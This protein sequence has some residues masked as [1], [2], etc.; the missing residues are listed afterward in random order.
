MSRSIF[1]KLEFWQQLIITFTIG[2]IILAITT[3]TALTVIANKSVKRQIIDQGL[4]LTDSIGRQARLALLYQSAVAA[5]DTARIALQFPDVVGVE[6][7]TEKGETLFREGEPVHGVSE[8]RVPDS[9]MLLHEDDNSLLFTAPV[10][11][12]RE[13]ELLWN[14]ESEENRS[15][16]EVIGYV[17]LVLSKSTLNGM[18]LQILRS[19]IAISTLVAIILLILLLFLT[20]RLTIPIRELSRVMRKAQSGEMNL[21]SSL[22][23]PRDIENM[24]KAFNTMMASLE[25]RTIELQNARDQALESAKVKSEFAANVSHELRTPMN[26]VVGMLDLLSVM[27]L[28]T[29]QYEYVET[30]KMSAQNLLA[31]IDDILSYVRS[32]SGNV[33]IDSRPCN[34]HQVLE[35]VINL[36][37]TQAL[38]KKL[39]VGY[40]ISPEVSSVYTDP[41]RLRQV[42]INLMGNA[43]KFTESGEISVHVSLEGSAEKHIL[44]VVNDTGIGISQEAQG[45]VFEA[46][47]QEDST[48]TRKYGGTG[49]GL[50]IC[51]QFIELMG[52]E[53]ALSS[54]QGAG[55]QFRFSVPYKP[56][57]PVERSFNRPD[58]SGMKVLAA[59]KSNIVRAFLSAWFENSGAS[60]DMADSAMQLLNAINEADSKNTQ[61][62]YIFIDENIPGITLGDLIPLIRKHVSAA[63]ADIV[64]LVNPWAVSQTTKLHDSLILEKPLFDTKL[65][66]FFSPSGDKKT[67]EGPAVADQSHDF[68]A[69]F[70][71]KVLVV[72]DNQ[73][74][75]LVAGGMLEKIGCE[76]ECAY[77]G[78][79]A[80]DLVSRKSFDAVLMDC[81]MPVMDG[82][83]A[84]S[85]IRKLEN[86][87]RQLPIIAMTANNSPEE[88]EHCL[89][90]G[91][92]DVI[93]KPLTIDVLQRRLLQWVEGKELDIGSGDTIEAENDVET[94]FDSTVVGSLKSSVGEVFSAVVEAFLEDVPM[95]LESLKAA[96]GQGDSRQ[97]YELAHTIKGSASNFGAYKVSTIA[98]AIEEKGQKEDLLGTDKLYL[99][100]LDKCKL[101]SRDL[102]NYLIEYREGKDRTAAKRE[103]ISTILVADDDRS[104]RIAFSNALRDEG[105]RILEASNGQSALALCSRAMP[106]L[107]LIDA[108][109]PELNG[110][111]A[112]KKIREMP[113]G[114]DVPILMVTSLEDEQSISRAFSVGATDYITK[115]ANFSVLRQRVARLLQTSRVEKHVRE[116]AYHDVLTGLPNRAS[117]NQQLRHKISRANLNGKKLAILFLDLD[118]FKLIND[119]L[120]HDAGD[121]ILKAAGER[122]NHCVRKND[123]VARLGGDEFTI[124]L[125][126]I[127]S[128]E[129]AG[130]ISNKICEA[131]NAPFVFLRQ[132]MF[133][134]ASVGISVYPD[135]GIDA[136][137]LLKH[138]DTAMFKAKESGKNY[139]YYQ[140]GMEDEITERLEIERGIR[141]AIEHDQ[142]VLFYQPQ[143]DL[144][145]GRVCGVEALVRWKHPERGIIPA[146]EFIPVVEE[147]GLV[148]E[149]GKVVMRQAVEQM[150]RWHE[151]GL[152]LKVA[153]NA[154]GGEFKDGR[155]RQQVF[156]LLAKWQVPASLLSVEITETTLMEHPELA[157]SELVAL[158]ERG[159]S[160]AIDDF[161]SG[162]S[163]LNYLKRF[164][165][166]VLKIDRDFVKDCQDDKNDQAIISGIITLARSLGLRV[167]AEGVEELSQLNFLRS[168]HCDVG[169]GY[170]FAKPLAASE[171]EEM[172]MSSS[173]DEQTSQFH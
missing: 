141:N 42:L 41:Q 170:Y 18:T 51:K 89:Q 1:S 132:K 19:N 58:C 26:S 82:Y 71:S 93:T 20:R 115:P 99:D 134:S 121:L 16:G 74:N 39:D 4:Y 59:D 28:D 25:T 7:V 31:L 86:D 116:L 6:I 60:V 65:S 81:N 104:M 50:A 152:D 156:D 128:R 3:S 56:A 136:G 160:I 154:S 113:E 37:A 29:K 40:I 161:G 100:L 92:D 112:C 83:E 146:G 88:K 22:K 15:D 139:F 23:G 44:F 142:I 55:S 106:D 158:R 79:D 143:I 148:G 126:D 17:T 169:Q 94:N 173:G 14:T 63:D 135:D 67:S 107:I 87:A 85:V 164:S 8:A 165:V 151:K 114:D 76:Y 111:S 108:I 38:R 130:D 64:T 43:I 32:D 150:H 49:L 147:T 105:Y 110:F 27:G 145:S 91:M 97:V 157:Q 166:D 48:T 62:D 133:V 103:E 11:T 72:D 69:A 53:I 98:R 123:L 12:Q 140:S 47:T 10:K 78:K 131:L 33:I 54:E 138:A 172:I 95:Y 13:Q 153:V 168:A 30:A 45:R 137:D 84:T 117:F 75:R 36:M 124:V 9:P 122:I 159:I 77:N 21:R 46:F 2:I 162:F 61:Y 119:S 167:V 35:D 120:G 5:G 24:Q 34:L 171:V 129:I 118:R 52:G 70:N 102:E 68:S 155:L 109:M 127:D 144:I 125:E 66:H 80:V 96:I 101:L 90:S 163:S 149:L 57:E 73:A